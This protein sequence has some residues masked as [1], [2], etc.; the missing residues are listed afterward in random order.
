MTRTTD[1]PQPTGGLSDR[2]RSLDGLRGVAAVVVV[3]HHVLL[4]FPAPSAAYTGGPSYP[5]WNWL[6]Y[7]PIHLLWAGTEAVMVFFLLSGIVLT[8]PVLRSAQFSLWAYYPSRLVRLYIPAITSVAFALILVSLVPRG[9]L[10]GRS[11]WLA[12]H[13]PPPTVHGVLRDVA[14]V[15]GADYLNSPLWSL[16][17]EVIFSL[18]LPVYVLIALRAGRAWWAVSLC[19]IAVSAVGAGLNL[20]V[21]EYLPLF[22]IG[23]MIAVNHD[24]IGRVADRLAQIRGSRWIWVGLFALALLGVTSRWSAAQVSKLITFPL[25]ELSATLLVILSIY[26]RPLRSRLESRAAQRLGL[27][28]FSL[29]LV[30]EPI[31]VTGAALFPRAAWAVPAV[32]V[33]VSVAAALLFAALVEQPAHRLAQRVRRGIE[34]RRTTSN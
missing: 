3:I 15:A 14:L 30:H 12:L 6:I 27:I 24:A 31:I 9:S 17:L 21:L 7:S 23:S 25:V 4:T 5:A 13:A 19:A 28:S 34:Q 1:I 33:P 16:R 20:Q 32:G 2:A 22:L 29:Y 11:E 26:W 8:L 18:L 10:A